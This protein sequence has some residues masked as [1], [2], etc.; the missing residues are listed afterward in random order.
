M[1]MSKNEMCNRISLNSFSSVEYGLRKYSYS[2]IESK[3]STIQLPLH[4]FL[5]NKR[6]NVDLYLLTIEKVL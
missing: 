4:V 2:V 6:N 1:R 3:V 5:T